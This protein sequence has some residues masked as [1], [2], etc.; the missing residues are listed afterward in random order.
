MPDSPETLVPLLYRELRRL[1]AGCLRSERPNHTLHPTALVH[2]A[3]LRLAGQPRAEWGDRAHFLA[4]AAH[5]MREVLIDHARTRNR[6]KR[7]A[8]QPLVRLEDAGELGGDAGV[9]LLA[10]E[11]ALHD[12]ER[13]DPQQHRIV[14]LRYFGGLSIEETAEVLGISPATVKRGWRMARAWLHRELCHDS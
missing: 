1:A 7:G 12:L 11:D 3:Y 4:V 5:V 9:D 14:E 8:G 2:E 6:A 10:L 13:I